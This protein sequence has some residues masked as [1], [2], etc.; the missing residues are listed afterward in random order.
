MRVD[1][2]GNVRLFAPTPQPISTASDAATARRKEIRAK[3][4]LPAGIGVGDDPS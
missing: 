4:V 1:V 2:S 3:M